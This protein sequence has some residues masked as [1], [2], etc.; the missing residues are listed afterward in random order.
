MCIGGVAKFIDFFFML[1]NTYSSLQSVYICRPLEQ[2]EVFPIFFTRNFLFDFSLTNSGSFCL[3]IAFFILFLFLSLIVVGNGLIVPTRWQVG[4][5][6]VYLFCF[7]II[8]DSAGVEGKAYFPFIF[9]LFIF[10]LCCN[11][12][13]LIPYRFTVTSHLAVTLFLALGIWFG[14]L[15]VGFRLHGMG[16][17]GMFIPM[18]IPF[19]IV[20]FLVSIELI[21]FLITAI[22]LPVRLFANM[23]AGHILLKVLGGFAW[24]ILTFGGMLYL[25]HF[26]PICSLFLLMG[27]ETGVALIQ[28]YVFTILTCLYLGDMIKGGHLLFFFCSSEVEQATVNRFVVG[29]NPTKRASTFF[30]V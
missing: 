7:G 12:I 13:G 17:L 2:F 11:V 21:G 16:L 20:P 10:I 18:G 26:L 4:I 14:K 27:L 19:L 24:T 1:L 29:S 25:A 8:V 5:E 3:F 6:F 15:F 22:R 30:C 23:I 9:T 28:A